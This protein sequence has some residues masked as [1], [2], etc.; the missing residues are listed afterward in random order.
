MTV[1]NPPGESRITQDA[2]T[3]KIK[4]RAPRSIFAVISS[5][6]IKAFVDLAGLEPGTHPMHVQTVIPQGVEVLSVT[7]DLVKFTIDP[8]VQKRMG[9][10]IVRSGEAPAGWTVAGIDPETRTVTVVGPQS[11]VATV[12]EVVGTVVVSNATAGDAD[13]EVSLQAVDEDGEVVESVRI[14]PKVISARVRYAR[15]L[16]R[17]V[18]DV[19]PTVEGTAAPGYTISEIRVEPARVE[20]AGTGAAL[21]AVTTL[22][23]EPISAA[24]LTESTSRTVSLV[25]PE[26]FDPWFLVRF[27]LQKSCFC[28]QLL[29]AFS[30]RISYAFCKSAIDL[31][32]FVLTDR[33]IQ[34]IHIC[35]RFQFLETFD[36][37]LKFLDLLRDGTHVD[38]IFGN[39]IYRFQHCLRIQNQRSLCLDSL[40]NELFQLLHVDLMRRTPLPVFVCVAMEIRVSLLNSFPN[41]VLTT[42]TAE[43]QS[44]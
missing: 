41:H 38:L 28:F 43:N 8:I 32:I 19:K 10:R 20:L 26:G 16:A 31:F 35:L 6:E 40:Q 39:A 2:E 23:T 37:L 4:L 17:K 15:S 13:I 24:D 34:H 11:V 7:P 27:I 18:V 30:D 14:V 25:L 12:A 3:V 44:G 36:L 21:D 9:V 1:L 42:A 5:D 29:V 22:S 33:F